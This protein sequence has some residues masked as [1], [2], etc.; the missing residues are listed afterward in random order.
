MT[1][2]E[3]PLREALLRQRV[4]GIVREASE[5]AAVASA[6]LALKRGLSVIEVSATTLGW[7]AAIRRLR[8]RFPDRRIGVG[9][10]LD[11]AVAE[12]ALEAG[13]DFLVTPS[14]PTD[15]RAILGLGAEV[16][17]GVFSPTDVGRAL[18]FG[19][20]IVKLFPA[21]ALGVGY[22]GALAGPFPGVDVV[23][24][25]GIGADTAGDWLAAGALAVGLGSN[26]A[27]WTPT[28]PT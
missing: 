23:A 16:L 8:E 21:A 25:G 28:G 11:A 5:D 20:G 14:I 26:L 6:S 27:E 7:D 12:R 24:V 19:L 10:V 13:A 2:R 22:L 17:P 18:E 15:L 3:S 4:L 1:S 9:T